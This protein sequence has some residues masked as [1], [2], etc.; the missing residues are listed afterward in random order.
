MLPFLKPKVVSGV[1][2]SYRKPDGQEE[3]YHEDEELHA[4]SEDFIQAVHAKDAQAVADA[5]RAAFECLESQPH[6]E[7]PHFEDEDDYLGGE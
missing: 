6:E 2:M 5:F 1:I 4:I 3:K 7:G